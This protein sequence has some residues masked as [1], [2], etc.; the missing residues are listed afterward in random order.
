MREPAYMLRLPGLKPPRWG[1]RSEAGA[2]IP[3]AAA[4]ERKK[5]TNEAT[6]S[7]SLTRSIEGNYVRTA[8]CRSVQNE[9]TAAPPPEVDGTNPALPCGLRRG[10]PERTGNGD[11]GTGN[12]MWR[13]EPEKPGNSRRDGRLQLTERTWERS[14]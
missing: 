10:R 13:N 9:A 6:E 3:E 8:A 11:R 14:L 7:F 2:T 5:C 4:G 12:G 1:G